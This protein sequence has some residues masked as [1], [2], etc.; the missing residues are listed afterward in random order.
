M[1]R[2]RMRMSLRK[3]STIHN[4]THLLPSPSPSP[5]KNN[6]HHRSNSNP[7]PNSIREIKKEQ[8]RKVLISKWQ[9]GLIHSSS[10]S[11][12]PLRKTK[13]FNH[14]SSI[15]I[16]STD[17]KSTSKDSFY[18]NHNLNRLST[19]TENGSS[20]DDISSNSFPSTLNTSINSTQ[21]KSGYQP[22]PLLLSSFN[23]SNKTNSSVNSALKRQISNL[24]K[25]QLQRHQEEILKEFKLKKKQD[26][27]NELS[28]ISSKL[29]PSFE[30][31]DDDHWD[32]LS[33]D[34]D[35]HDQLTH[36][37]QEEEEEDFEDSMQVVWRASLDVGRKVS[38]NRKA[39][40]KSSVCFLHLSWDLRLLTDPI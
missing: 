17:D 10:S 3:E 29:N 37:H 16:S 36:H 33:S 27:L 11:S 18:S 39:L 12:S 21:P 15:P 7:S 22:R 38:R 31:P 34:S 1:M 32:W 25:R 30:N 2:M 28:A 9:N 24:E 14:Q 4:M 26:R 35:H 8:D 23:Q 20:I 40:G 13:S 19:F 5:S 6:Q